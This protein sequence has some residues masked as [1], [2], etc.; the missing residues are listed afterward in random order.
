MKYLLDT[1]VVSETRKRNPDACLKKWLASVSSDDL[2][3]SVVTLGELRKGSCLVKDASHRQEIETWID[4]VVTPGF[5]GR[6][7]SFDRR[8]ADQWGRLMGEGIATGRTPSVTD[9]MIAA[10][11]FAQGMT[12]VTRNTSDFQ[13]EGLKVINPF[14]AD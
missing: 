13:F 5:A 10:T 9:S 2:F 11:A 12:V 1:C 3:L 7:V 14:V 8:M 6:V 4:A